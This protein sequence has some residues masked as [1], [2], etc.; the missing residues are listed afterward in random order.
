M[1]QVLSAA[2]AAAM[3]KNGATVMF[4]GFL[5]C[6]NPNTMVDALL[7]AGVEDLTMIA[8]DA[9]LPECG[10]GRLIVQK[11]VKKGIFSHIGLNPV[12]GAQ[13]TAGETEMELIPQGTL[14]ER[15]RC[16]GSG[17]GGFL[18][19]TGVGTVVEEGKQRIS[20]NGR[21]YLLELPLR[22]EVAI[23]KAFRADAAGNLIYRYTARNF[24]PLMAMAADL[25]IAEV[26]EIVETGAI[27]PDE[28]HTP[29]IFIDYMVKS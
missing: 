12:A 18:T 19:P 25:V 15:I 9:A 13:M 8:N 24:N 1:K 26:E 20:V 10:I 21:D 22:A 28:V 4:G 2:Q 27:H 3:V 11:R 29:G 16:G 23:I 7:A 17:L 14:A 5:G 6:G